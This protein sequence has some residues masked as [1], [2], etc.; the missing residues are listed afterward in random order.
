MLFPAKMVEVEVLVHDSAQYRVLQTMQRSGFM[1]IT[2]HRIEELNNSS[3]SEDVG[4]L[5]DY[6]FRISKLMSIL[7]IARKREGGIKAMLSPPAPER[8]DAK[9]RDRED[10]IEDA[11]STLGMLEEKLTELGKRWDEIGDE[12]DR[13][14]VQLEQL[15]MLSG[16][17]FDVSLLGEGMYTVISAGTAKEIENLNSLKNEG[18][19]AL[20]YRT[21]GKKNPTYVIVLAYLLRHR[22]EVESALRF[23]NFSEFSFSDV[24]GKPAEAMAQLEKRMENLK[25]EKKK[26]LEEISKMRE[27]HYGHLAVLYDDLDNEK[28]KEESK[29]KFGKTN[30]TTVIRGY[31]KKKEIEEAKSK[32]EEAA[33]GLAL[34]KW[35]DAQG[36]ETPS[37]F[38]NPKI[39]HPFQA[40]VEMYSVPKYGYIDPTAIIAP[41]FVIYFGLTLGDAGYGF[42]M[43]VLGYL[44][45]FHIGRYDWTNRTLG[46]ILFASG[47]SAIVFGII[48]GGIFG[49]LDSNNPMSQLVQYQPV[50]DPMKDAVTVLVIAL[51]VGMAQI[52]LGLILGA[53]HH[54]K[55]KNYGDF[56]TSELSWF[57]LLPS[58]AVVIGS[59]FGWW[60]VDANLMTWS[61]IVLGIGLVF[62][63]GVPGHFVDRE[64]AVN[65]MAFFDITGM[66]GDWLSYSRLLALDLGTSGIALT[67]NLFAG[68]MRSMITSAGSMVCCM[69][70]AIVGFAL[71]GL[72]AKKKDKTKTG[73]AAFLLLL[74]LLGMVSL[75][76]AL[77]LF[78]GIFLVVAHIGNAMLQSLGSLVHSLR[79]QYVEF[80]SKF[81]EGDGVKFE[82]FKEIRKN[83]KLVLESGGAKR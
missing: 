50:I 51:I 72:V 48:Q 66:V 56:L 30:F 21:Y 31:V 29:S 15:N 81:Y 6:E 1:H 17:D 63:T 25:E 57:L 82:P 26:L 11:R 64:H 45:W 54:L 52:S 3:P 35:K 83:T 38:N 47:I 33:D 32:I 46:K 65:A 12:E 18:K 41:L 77:W 53:Y 55:Y 40:F 60:S 28:I 73:I 10:I 37:A 34:V 9:P 2:H 76:A 62:L 67:I 23:S 27:E 16:L 69:P 14:K 8:F 39:L 44:L 74:G 78:I 49:P 42:I 68:I 19:L 43:T 4:L 13:I 79:L 20:W 75:Q 5:V 59:S 22:K 24:H 80:F 7:N 70:L 71:F 61:W 36:P 58:S